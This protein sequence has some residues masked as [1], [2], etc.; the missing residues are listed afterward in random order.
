VDYELSKGPGSLAPR[1]GA[2]CHPEN[3]MNDEAQLEQTMARC[4]VH[5][6][7]PPP[8]RCASQLFKEI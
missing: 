4:Y 7:P 5:F 3:R 1:R 8:Q 2:Q 6:A